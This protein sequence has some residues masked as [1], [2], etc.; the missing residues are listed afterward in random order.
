MIRNIIAIFLLFVNSALAHAIHIAAPSIGLDVT[1][2]KVSR[3]VGDVTPEMANQYLMQA[4]ATVNLPG[5]RVIVIDSLG[6][7]VGAGEAIIEAIEAEKAVDV[8]V[9]C[10]V[11]AEATSMAFNILTHCS[12]R[13]ATKN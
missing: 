7:Y 6:G 3:V 4:L 1:T 2:D 13:L 12:V 11:K 8:K 10:I 5:P 9:I